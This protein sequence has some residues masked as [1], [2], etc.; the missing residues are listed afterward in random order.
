MSHRESGGSPNYSFKPSVKA[1]W[2]F[3]VF[4]PL[5]VAL[6]FWQLQRAD[7]KVALNVLRDTRSQ[8]P[9]RSLKDVAAEVLDDLRYRP[10]WMEGQY[11][12]A[13]Q[14]L[15]DNQLQG[16]SVGYQVLTPLRLSGMD[17]AVLVNRGWVP[18]GSS[19]RVLPN[20]DQAPPGT[21]K[22]IGI[23]ERFHR[24]GFQLE[25]ADIPADGWPSVVQLPQAEKLAER[26]G[27]SVL[28]Y[29]VLLDPAA[30]GGY[31]RV[32][33][34]VRLDSD[35]NRGYA[36]QWFLFAGLVTFF[37]VRYSFKAKSG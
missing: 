22:V 37:F 25:G 17:K 10:V 35:K 11:D 29:Q 12:T 30:D 13:H 2:L 24:V 15:L 7:E 5:F 28:P 19:R 32:W 16:Q 34:V 14:F 23:V 33:Q 1:V 4:F 9:P 20:I 18:Q 27:Y 8:E 36:L 31:S 26:L 6:G 21:M 3:A